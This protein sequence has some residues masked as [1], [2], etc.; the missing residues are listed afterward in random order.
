MGLVLFIFAKTSTNPMQ[1]PP[2]IFELRKELHQHPELSGAEPATAGRIASFLTLHTPTELI[3]GIGGHGVAAVYRFADEGPTVV[4]RC[5]L[6]ALPIREVND[7]SHRSL[8][9]GISHKCGHDG[10]MAILAG[11]GLWLKK[12]SFQ[13]GKVVLLFQPAEESGQGAQA[14][15]QEER[16]RQLQPDYIFALHNLPGVAM[17]T[18]VQAEGVF[19]ATVQS[20]MI[21]L[22][23]KQAHASEPENGINPALAV[24]ELIQAFD[25]LNR[26]T[27]TDPDFAL[28][29]PVCLEMGERSYGISA[30][31]GALHYTLR[32]WTEASMQRLKDQVLTL[33]ADICHRH[34]LGYA[35]DWFDYFP[36]TVNDSECNRLINRVANA[37]GL[38]VNHRE[39]PLKFG[40]DFGWFSREYKIG[41]FGLGAGQGTPALHHHDYDFP[42]ELLESGIRMFAGIIREIMR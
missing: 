30:G 26:P 37:E 5:E 2:S 38:L 27:T 1:V 4:I 34:R 18:I 19:T 6:D 42:D 39:T 36:A 14:V 11:L 33:T 9:P 22:E 29:T 31:A 41:M 8:Y 25:R 10:H 13:R 35:T 17:H 23:G 32:T 40:E 20:V 15:L 12:Q 16:F 24:A 7:F 3:R 21:R 28:L